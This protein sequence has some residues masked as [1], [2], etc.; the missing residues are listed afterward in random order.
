MKNIPF[1]V[2]IISTLISCDKDPV[3][4]R[5]IHNALSKIWKSTSNNG[6][7]SDDFIELKMDGTYI[8]K[9]W[10]NKCDDD[11]KDIYG[12]WE[13]REDTLKF[14]YFILERKKDTI[15]IYSIN[16]ITSDILELKSIN[17]VVLYNK[18]S[19]PN[20]VN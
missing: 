3:I 17:K 8:Y 7:E 15:E 18:F 19:P 5:N 2:L 14:K 13:Y 1:I 11:E 16:K 12:R 20:L 9:G 10:E 4:D 6:C